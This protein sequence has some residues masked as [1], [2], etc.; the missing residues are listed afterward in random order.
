[1]IQTRREF[2]PERFKQRTEQLFWAIIDLRD[3]NEIVKRYGVRHYTNG[4]DMGLKLQ[5]IAAKAAK[6]EHDA[7]FEAAKLDAKIE[8]VAARM[9]GVFSGAHG[10]VDK[11]AQNVGDIEGAFSAIQSV[12]NGA[13]VDAVEPTAMPGPYPTY[14]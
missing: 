13:P 6:L 10:S 5:G 3:E 14:P 4:T 11:L 1:M 8:E 7:E 2:S 9:P 12:T